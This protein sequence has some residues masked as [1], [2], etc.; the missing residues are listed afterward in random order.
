MTSKDPDDPEDPAAP[1][2]QPALILP[3][4]VT[5]GRNS[6]PPGKGQRPP[7]SR[8]GKVGQS[9][10]ANAGRKAAPRKS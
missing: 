2:R 5:P 9:R 8:D 6:I 3:K 10:T 4:G 1:A 7:Q